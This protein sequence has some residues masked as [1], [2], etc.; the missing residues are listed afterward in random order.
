MVPP[1]VQAAFDATKQDADLEAAKPSRL[2]EIIERVT[3]PFT[4]PVQDVSYAYRDKTELS[5]KDRTI[6]DDASKEVQEDWES[7]KPR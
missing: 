7:D 3:T 1:H 4:G 2:K 6:L 5:G